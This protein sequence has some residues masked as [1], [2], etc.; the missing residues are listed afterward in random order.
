MGYGGLI[1]AFYIFAAIFI[2]MLITGSV[3]V[4]TGVVKYFKNGRTFTVGAKKTLITGICIAAVPL[5]LLLAE[6][7]S[8][9]GESVNNSRSLYYQ[10]NSGTVD[11]MRR[12]LESGVPAATAR[13]LTFR[14][15][16]MPPPRARRLRYSAIS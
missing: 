3:L 11:G 13:L 7:I 4:V 1:V 10:A 15:K 6:G 16:Q 5:S 2:G 12:I 14:G 9:I 8:K